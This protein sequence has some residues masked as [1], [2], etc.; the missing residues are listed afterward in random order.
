QTSSN[1]AVKKRDGKVLFDSMEFGDFKLSG[2]VIG[3]GFTS[4][5]KSLIM[6]D[7]GSSVGI[8]LN[9]SEP[10]PQVYQPS[11]LPEDAAAKI[12][13]V[14]ERE[15]WAFTSSSVALIT[16]REDDSKVVQRANVAFGDSA[17]TVLSVSRAQALLKV[18]ENYQIISGQGKF[19]LNLATRLDYRGR[20]TPLE[21]LLGFGIAGDE[22][23]WVSDGSKIVFFKGKRGVLAD[24]TVQRVQV[25]GLTDSST[26]SF[27]FEEVNGE[28]QLT[29][30]GLAYSEKNGR[31]L[32][33]QEL[34]ADSVSGPVAVLEID[35]PESRELVQQNC[36]SCHGKSGGFEEA[37]KID[38]W[39]ANAEKIKVQLEKNKMPP[40]GAQPEARIKLAALLEK[41]T[42]VKAVIKVDDEDDDR[43]EPEVNPRVAEFDNR[44]KAIIEASCLAACHD[45]VHGGTAPPAI[46]DTIRR[47]ARG[48][49]ARMDS[50][51]RPMPPA[52]QA[53][54]I[55]PDNRAAL[56]QWLGTLNP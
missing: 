1:V 45:H 56:S 47:N 41:L 6:L 53:N 9:A 38:S 30:R 55:T 33:S 7:N 51:N 39:K 24:V 15:Y 36:L 18:G 17:P 25:D 5:N 44:Y 37:L 8:D 13:P 29:G 20:T 28:P 52:N 12:Y 42:S 35:D 3:S 10:T 46:F 49:K 2:K 48:M 32:R 23:F 40:G 50:A 26:V 11:P 54:R 4:K 16:Y 31:F 19:G 43:S 22:R 34:G 21:T 27:Q 14:G